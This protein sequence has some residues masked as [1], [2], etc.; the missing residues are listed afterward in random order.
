M[1]YLGFQDIKNN[2]WLV[3]FI[4]EDFVKD[5][6]LND[7]YG[8][9]QIDACKEFI[10]N[11]QVDI[12]LRHRNDKDRLPC[13]T[14]T[15]NPSQEADE[16]K[17]MGDASTCTATLFPNQIGKPISYIVKSFVPLS[18]DVD[19]GEV[20]IDPD[21][22]G[23]E[24][25]GPGMILVNPN[26]GVGTQIL[27]VGP[28]F[29]LIEAGVQLHG[30]NLAIV[31][32]F[33]FYKARIEHT[34]FHESY[35]VGVHAHGDP[36]VT[37]WLHSIVMYTLLRYRESM[38]EGRGFS[39]TKLTSSDLIEN[40]NYTGPG[41][42]MAFSRVI[43]VSG[44]TEQSWVKA[45][46]RIIEDVSIADKTKGSGCDPDMYAGGIKILSNSE[47]DI[48]EKDSLWYPI[49]EDESGD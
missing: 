8:Q 42:E 24:K 36:Q 39:Q 7:L 32:Q 48:D 47:P 13:I 44:I 22:K 2:P 5:P 37:L 38:L 11:N 16:L 12:Y 35:S 18:Y 49:D 6:Y 28:D 26:T 31:P 30:S 33:Q 43:T 14:I 23:Y 10:A 21:T 15:L 29:I 1:I 34:M 4:L 40:P 41:G 19:N 25:I 45:P 27:D 20:G 46:H 17:T 3:D 9:K